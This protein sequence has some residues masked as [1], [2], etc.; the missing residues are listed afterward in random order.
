M[1]KK[2]YK[3]NPKLMSSRNNDLRPILR[4]MRLR[5]VGVEI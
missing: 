2:T 3:F 5:D 1:L 4:R